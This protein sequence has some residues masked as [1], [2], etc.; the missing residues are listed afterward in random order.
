MRKRIDRSF[1]RLALAGVAVAAVASTPLLGSATGLANSPFAIRAINTDGSGKFSIK[2]FAKSGASQPGGDTGSTTPPVSDP[3]PTRAPDATPGLVAMTIDTSL[4]SC[5]ATTT[6]FQLNVASVNSQDP[7]KMPLSVN[8]GVN[9]GDSSSGDLATGINSHVYKAGKYNLTIDGKLGG[10][11]SVA[12]SAASCISRVD[13]IGENTG[14]VTLEGFLKSGTNLSY[15]AAPPTSLTNGIS[16][17]DGAN[18]FRGDGSETWVLPNLAQSSNMFNRAS[19]FNGDLS[20]LNPKNLQIASGMFT[21]T[22]SFI[23][24]GLE[25]WKTPALTSTASMFLYAKAF[26]APIGVWDV[27]HVTTFAFMFGYTNTFNQDIS[28]WNVSS[29]KSFRSM[30]T[31]AFAF[32]QPL[33]SWDVSSAIDMVQMFMSASKFNQ[34][35]NSWNVSNV[36]DMTNIFRSASAF[37]GKVSAWNTAK[38][39]DMFY[40]FWGTTNFKQDVSKWNV[41]RVTDWTGFYNYSALKSNPSLVPLKFQNSTGANG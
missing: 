36:T 28:S 19:I 13:H 20:N 3:E 9:W 10:L 4:P 16:M 21:N 1:L 30:F 5:Q 23:G 12:A 27:S 29:G 8:A 24:K 33:D 40:A 35:L 41:N 7:A 18:R 37:N 14:I 32:N 39:A 15:F 38:V 6:G 34:D 17:L 22:D 2:P 11:N 31:S 25:K 26:N